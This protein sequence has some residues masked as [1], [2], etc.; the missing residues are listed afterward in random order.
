MHRLDLGPCCVCGATVRVRTIISLNK[1]S[2]IA[3]H[4]WGC[5]VCHLPAD[6]A[7]A[8]V[9]DGCAERHGREVVAALQYACRGYPA[10]EGRVPIGELVGE[11]EHDL[12]AHVLDGQTV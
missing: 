4:G 10:V 6:G 9:C 12:D 8:A 1:K 3:G 7:Q 11:H 5:F 2:P